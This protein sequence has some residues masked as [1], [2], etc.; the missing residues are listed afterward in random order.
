MVYILWY[1]TAF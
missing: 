1:I